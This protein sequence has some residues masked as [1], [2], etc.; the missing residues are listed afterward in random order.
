MASR[1]PRSGLRRTRPAEGSHRRVGPGVPRLA[2]PSRARAE[3]HRLE[4]VL[5]HRPGVEMFFGLLEPYSFLYERAFRMDEAGYEHDALE[6][7]LR[8]E[9]VRVRHLIHLALEI[10][11]DRP[12][13][14]EEVRREALRLV[15]YSGP[16]RMVEA[17]RSE[18]RR[19][20]DR[21][22]GETLF[23]ILLLRPSVH[24]RR[25]PGVRVILP[26][27]RLDTPLANLYFMRDQQALT[28]KGYVLGR[29]SKPQRQPEPFLTGALLRIA[30]AQFAGEI[31]APGTFEGGDFLPMGEFA[32]LGTGDRTNASAVRQILSMPTGVDEIA[33]VHQPSHPAVPGDAP[34]PM[35]DM[36]LDTYLNVPGEKIVVG[37]GPLLDRART[38]VFVRRGRGALSRTGRAV[39]LREY[40]RG[41]GFEV[42]EISTLEQM[43]YASN[44][45][46]L[47]DRRILA[48]EVEDEVDRVLATLASAARSS[49][50]RYGALLAVAR[51]DRRELQEKN[52]FFPHK[53][54]FRELGVDAVPL[55]LRE[56]TGGYGGA[57]CMTCVTRRAGS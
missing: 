4:E 13:I 10:G 32:L 38:E 42:V 2:R 25:R 49:P 43:S 6:H 37:C 36:H 57:H 20:L 41:K 48:V 19:N 23:N 7:A 5:I 40:L 28:P 3:W 52:D 16:K 33:V 9:G 8:T 24:L 55:D 53:R 12:E 22:D 27:V 44:F 45:L 26:E 47:R 34:D 29:M 18:L 30:G 31:R 51:R 56:I 17:A 21:L 35:I 14:I 15:H 11:Q 39:P 46:C 1:A 54:A 50:H